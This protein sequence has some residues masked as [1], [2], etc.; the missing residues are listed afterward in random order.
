VLVKIQVSVVADRAWSPRINLVSTPENYNGNL[1]R[2]K[3]ATAK[4][5]DPR[6]VWPISIEEVILGSYVHHA[7]PFSPGD[8]KSARLMR[9]T[10]ERNYL[11]SDAGGVEI[12]IP[13]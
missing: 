3:S 7:A 12:D 5:Y 10:C 1:K 4:P 9:P 6:N 13:S 11:P 2:N 8:R